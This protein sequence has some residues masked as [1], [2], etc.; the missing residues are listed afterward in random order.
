MGGDLNAA[1]G[2]DSTAYYAR[3]LR[4]TWR[5]RST[6]SATSSLSPC[7]IATS[8]PASA[9]SSCRR[10]PQLWTSPDD[11]AFDLVEDAAFPDQPVGRSILGTVESVSRLERAHLGSI[12]R[13]IIGP[14]DMVLAA[15]GAVDHAALMAEA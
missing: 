6:S 15:A 11:I 8:L 12:S 7:S 10:S 4:K 1:T 14:A 13:R 2:V 5:W 9:T 3:V